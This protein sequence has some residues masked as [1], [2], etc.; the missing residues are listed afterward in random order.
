[1][2]Q[3]SGSWIRKLYLGVLQ[4]KRSHSLSLEMG[5]MIRLR[6]GFGQ[7]R[8]VHCGCKGLFLEEGSTVWKGGEKVRV[9]VLRLRV[10]LTLFVFYSASS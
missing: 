1:M 9:T 2:T 6:N 7:T 3:P 5:K 4:K 10:Y 8:Q